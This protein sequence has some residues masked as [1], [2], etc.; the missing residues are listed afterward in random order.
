[1]YVIQVA[2]ECAPV[3]KVGGLADV[4]FGLSWE[5][6]IRG[7]E[8]EIILPKYDCMRYDHIWGLSPVY[9]DLWVPWFGEAIHCTVL[10]GHVHGRKC[11]FIDPHSEDRFFNRNTFYG[12]HDD[13]IRYAFFCK[14]ALEFMLK[15]GKRP[16]VVHCHDW[17][18]GLLPVMLADIYQ[19]NG[20]DTQRVCYTIHNFKHQG[21]FGHDV[22]AA[23][24][25]GRPEHYYRPEQLRDDNNPS[26]LNCMK[27]GIVYSNF[28][29]TV[30]PNH[31]WEARFTD[32]S[33]GLGHALH[34]H[35]DKFG[36]ILNGVDYSTWN[37]E[38]D[39]FIP[40]QYSLETIEGKYGNKDALRDRL[41]LYKSEK[42]IVSYVGRL[43]D[44]KGLNLICHAAH[45]ALGRGAQFV[46]LGSC[47][48]HEIFNQFAQLRNELGQ[49]VDCHIE[50]G[51][52]EE[53]A[54][55][56]YAGSDM[57]IVPSAFEPCGLTQIIALR[58]GTVPVVRSV[59]GLTDTVFDKDNS[60]VDLAQRNGYAFDSYDNFGIESALNRAIGL[61]YD[62]PQDF[63]Q[64]MINGMKSD[65]SWNHPGIHYSNVYEYIRHK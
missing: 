59:G 49:S 14:A 52:N 33:H 60:H 51:F 16:D 42:P 41:W 2:S 65:Y 24:G 22:L 28:I 64:L 27:G 3:A 40:S 17:Q 53:L 37:P 31:A 44:Q 18:T 30:S 6:A 35:Q 38:L 19:H 4:V 26:V 15:S 9:E 23:T 63:R 11:Y 55:L 29:T 45:Y 36:G 25:L 56:I 20:L 8:V 48:N 32:Q 43:D 46:L 12:C 58:Y 13:V 39:G 10:F 57:M 7:N 34:V 21:I 5:L 47:S 1:M 61:F 54:H 62:F 50:L